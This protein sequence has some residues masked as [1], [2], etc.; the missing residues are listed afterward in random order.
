MDTLTH[1]RRQEWRDTFAAAAL[2]ALLGHPSTSAAFATRAEREEIVH[3]K[4]ATEAYR[5]A[6]AMLKVRRR[7]RQFP[8]VKVS[9]GG[10]A[11]ASS[12]EAGD[13]GGGPDLSTARPKQI[14]PTY[15]IMT[16][17]YCSRSEK[18]PVRT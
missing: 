14:Q 7:E 12:T 18:S 4:L 6:G 3:E 5:W 11:L 10:H 9:G 16:M 2:G 13:D 8:S 17:I 15:R 1:E